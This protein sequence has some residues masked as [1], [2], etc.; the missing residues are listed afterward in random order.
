MLLL[1]AAIADV[2]FEMDISTYIYLYMWFEVHIDLNAAGQ[3]NQ[4][5]YMIF[6]CSY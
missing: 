2:A 6:I 3:F 1:D 4:V 5:V